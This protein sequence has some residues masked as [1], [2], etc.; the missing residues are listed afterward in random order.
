MTTVI[1]TEQEVSTVIS[2]PGTVRVVV[3]ADWDETDSSA[4][5]YIENKP[6]IPADLSSVTYKTTVEC[7]V[8]GPLSAGDLINKKITNRGQ[9][10]SVTTTLP[11]FTDNMYFTIIVLATG[12]SWYLKP[13]VGDIIILDGTAL[14]AGD[15]IL[16]S[17]ASLYDQLTCY[18][19]QTGASTYKLMAEIVRGTSFSDGGI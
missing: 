9:V 5:G 4:E 13:Q 11:T 17:G 14:D 10:G 19:I 6:T 12:N 8:T 1:T 15:Q 3:Q 16:I 18:T 2:N 7:S